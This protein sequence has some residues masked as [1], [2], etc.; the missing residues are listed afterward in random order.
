[1]NLKAY[2]AETAQGSHLNLPYVAVSDSSAIW[3]N[4]VAAKKLKLKGGTGVA[5]FQ[6]EDAPED[7]YLQLGDK[8]EFFRLRQK[9]GPSQLKLNNATTARALYATAKPRGWT[10]KSV[11]L[12]IQ[13][14]PIEIDGAKYYLI[15]TKPL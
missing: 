14:K 4:S 3:F 10:K 15:I 11:R 2:N 8:P 5:F 9:G 1:M 7:W 13:E 6:N 12:R